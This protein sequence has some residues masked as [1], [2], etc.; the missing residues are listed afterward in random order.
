MSTTTENKTVVPPKAE[1]TKAGTNA[2]TSTPEKKNEQKD[3]KTG[4]A[5]Y[6]RYLYLL[7]ASSA[8]VLISYFAYRRYQKRH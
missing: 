2:T 7:F 6:K 5:K 1:A 3:K 8:G 4:L